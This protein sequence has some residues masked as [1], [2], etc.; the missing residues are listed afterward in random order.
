MGRV[1]VAMEIVAAALPAWTP[2]R[3]LLF[4]PPHSFFCLTCPVL[5]SDKTKLGVAMAP[6]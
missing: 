1:P 3:T 6:T 5:P 4:P 2:P